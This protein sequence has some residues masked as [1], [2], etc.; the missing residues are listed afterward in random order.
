MSVL[1]A[2][3]DVL[4]TTLSVMAAEVPKK[5]HCPNFKGTVALKYS[6]YFQVFLRFTEKNLDDKSFIKETMAIDKWLHR[7]LDENPHIN[8]S[9]MAII[10]ISFS[11][12]VIKV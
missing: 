11:T 5:S 9:F 12:S 2:E 3:H 7:L 8:F 10:C 6:V 1:E 4:Q